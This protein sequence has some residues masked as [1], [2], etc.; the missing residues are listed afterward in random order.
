[1]SR[2]KQLIFVIFQHLTVIFMHFVCYAKYLFFMKVSFKPQP[3][4]IKL[5]FWSQYCYPVI[6][7]MN[8]QLHKF[9]MMSILT[10]LLAKRET[11]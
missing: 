4:V 11:E 10:L 1:M 7:Y 8:P 9:N 2:S 6:I 3:E 5:L